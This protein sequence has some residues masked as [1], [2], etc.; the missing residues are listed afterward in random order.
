LLEQ[1]AEVSLAAVVLVDTGLP[2]GLA[3]AVHLLKPL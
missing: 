2:Q 3:E 1:G